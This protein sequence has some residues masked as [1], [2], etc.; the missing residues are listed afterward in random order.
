MIDLFCCVFLDM[1]VNLGQNFIS[2]TD[3]IVKRDLVNLKTEMNEVRKELSK[4]MSLISKSQEKVEIDTKKEY[5][6]VQRMKSDESGQQL[7]KNPLSLDEIRQSN[8]QNRETYYR[9]KDPS[10]PASQIPQIGTPTATTT[11][12]AKIDP[13]TISLP[14]GKLIASVRMDKT[15][16]LLLGPT[17]RI[18][19]PSFFP[20]S[21]S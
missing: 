3:W 16:I 17:G 14:S 12:E 6:M 20:I 11:E 13:N 19:L 7:Q 5:T 8:L 2:N 4:A 1:S 9:D 10:I 18:C 21:W 15:N